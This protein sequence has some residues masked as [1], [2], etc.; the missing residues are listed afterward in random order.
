M[1]EEGSIQVAI[2]DNTLYLKPIGCA[3][4][5]NCLGLPDFLSAMFRA[6]CTRVLVDLEECEAMDSTFLGV[7]AFAATCLPGEGRKIVA[8][9]NA[10]QRNVKDIRTVGLA[11]LVA[12]CEPPCRP[13]QNLEL[14]QIDFV[15][16]PDTETERLERIKYLHELL[17]G[18]N[19]TCR[20]QFCSFLDMLE[21]ELESTQG[22]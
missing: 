3:T 18:L 21:K 5:Q 17:A 8:V 4:Q 15:H 11:P 12:M 20:R 9:L 10:N 1:A 22:N 2:I 7:I 13:P 16:L 14:K 6:G 19:E